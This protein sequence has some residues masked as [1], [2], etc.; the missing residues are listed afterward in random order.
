MI[1]II[2]SLFMLYAAVNVNPVPPYGQAVDTKLTL[3]KNSPRTQHLFFS[4]IFHFP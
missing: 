2:P 1:T 3:G 4:P